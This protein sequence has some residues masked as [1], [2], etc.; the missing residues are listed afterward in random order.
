ME[1]ELVQLERFDEKCQEWIVVQHDDIVD[2]ATYR[3][4]KVMHYID[5]EPRRAEQYLNDYCEPLEMWVL[6]NA[7]GDEARYRGATMFSD[8]LHRFQHAVRYDKELQQTV[9]EP[10]DNEALSFYRGFM[11]LVDMYRSI[12]DSDAHTT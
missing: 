5:A 9:T 3:A 4:V 1:I 2:G 6:L 12:A 8:E 11:N 10:I 7:I